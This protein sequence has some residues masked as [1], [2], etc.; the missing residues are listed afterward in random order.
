M[1]FCA[2]FFCAFFPWRDPAASLALI[3]D[4]LCVQKTKLFGARGSARGPNTDC[5]VHFLRS[6]SFFPPPNQKI[7]M[8]K[9]MNLSY[10][11]VDAPT[12]RF[13]YLLSQLCVVNHQE[14]VPWGD[15]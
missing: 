3:Y 10:L 1:N 11:S 7:L 2:N 8:R 15:I 5:K 14:M 4:F 9:L 12:L 6:R 13:H